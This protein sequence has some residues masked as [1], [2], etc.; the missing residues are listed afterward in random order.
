MLL[1]GLPKPSLRLHL[2]RSSLSMPK[3]ACDHARP[4]GKSQTAEDTSAMK[5]KNLFMKMRR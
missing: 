4:V 5:A 1:I 2:P 3:K